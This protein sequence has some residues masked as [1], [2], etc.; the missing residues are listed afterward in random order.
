[1][2]ISTVFIKI[3]GVPSCNIYVPI[4]IW[5]V[6]GYEE[7]Y[8]TFELSCHATTAQVKSGPGGHRSS[9]AAAVWV[10]VNCWG[11]NLE[12]G[13]YNFFIGIANNDIK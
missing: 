1:M 4:E 10:L 11:W 7:T 5:Q 9:A 6:V 12:G 3:L 13:E 8:P 2:A